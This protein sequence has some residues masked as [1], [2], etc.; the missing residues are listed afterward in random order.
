MQLKQLKFNGTSITDIRYFIH[1]L[2]RLR[3]LCDFSEG[4][5]YIC[6]DNGEQ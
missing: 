5:V 3:D 2:A 4:K 1:Q 6:T